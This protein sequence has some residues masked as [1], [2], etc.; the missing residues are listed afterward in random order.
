MRNKSQLQKIMTRDLPTLTRQKRLSYRTSDD[1][2]QYLYEIIN[3]EVFH[4]R[5]IM[6]EIIVKSRCRQYWGVCSA[7]TLL[8]IIDHDESN[9][10]IILSDKWFCQQWLVNTLAHEMVHQY[11]WDVLSVR[12]V[13]Q[14]LGPIMSHGPSFFAF[15]PKLAKHYISLKTKHA[16]AKWFKHQNLFKC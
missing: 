12:R 13:K 5:L 14:G 11:Q 6:P 8:P 10:G 1:E 16:R 2:V 7:K 15:K 3:H 9:C 4:D